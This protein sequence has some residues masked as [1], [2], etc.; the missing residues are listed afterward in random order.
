MKGSRFAPASRLNH[1]GPQTHAVNCGPAAG[2]PCRASGPGAGGTPALVW[3]APHLQGG[4]VR[5]SRVSCTLVSGLCGGNLGSRALMESAHASP[6][7]P[8][9]LER[10]QRGHRLVAC[11]SDL[12][13]H[14]RSHSPRNTRRPRCRQEG[15]SCRDPAPSALGTHQRAVVWPWGGVMAEC[16]SPCRLR[17][18]VLLAGQQCPGGARALVRQCH[19]R[20]VRPAPCVHRHRPAAAP[21]LAP[22][23]HPQRRASP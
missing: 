10:A 11:R 15:S 2:Y 7:L 20:D 1:R 17:A 22:R 18:I 14:Q 19:R 12:S 5:A 8:D 3:S 16:L 13:C 21:V 4:V 6:H 9:G 23:R